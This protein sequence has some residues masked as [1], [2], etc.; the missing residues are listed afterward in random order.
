MLIFI[1]L[2]VNI[3]VRVESQGPPDDEAKKTVLEEYIRQYRKLFKM[4]KKYNLL[5]IH[6][7]LEF[8]RH[9]K[10][11]AQKI[12]ILVQLKY[13][14]IICSIW[15][16]KVK[17]FRLRSDPQSR[18]MRPISRVEMDKQYMKPIQVWL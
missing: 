7:Q 4:P 11:Q 10:Y 2:L 8:N 6:W 9:A 5:T 17:I 16:P 15:W 3:P 14:R 1:Y 13:H 18:C 12:L